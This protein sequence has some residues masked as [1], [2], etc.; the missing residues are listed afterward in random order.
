MFFVN[1]LNVVIGTKLEFF[2]HLLLPQGKQTLTMH[3]SGVAAVSA[4]GSQAKDQLASLILSGVG[5]A[6]DRLRRRQDPQ[7]A[8]ASLRWGKTY[9]Q[10]ATE[11]SEK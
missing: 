7:Q 3:T 1:Q 11:Q 2:T 6:R 10:A 4:K 8:S 9:W 5:S